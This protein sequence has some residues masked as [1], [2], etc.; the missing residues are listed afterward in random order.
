M[1]CTDGHGLFTKKRYN[2]RSVHDMV[3]MPDQVCQPVL[4]DEMLGKLANGINPRRHFSMTD[5]LRDLQ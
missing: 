2:V 3:Q 5:G 4:A 1:L